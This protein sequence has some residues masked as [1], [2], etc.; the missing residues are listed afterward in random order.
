MSRQTR[1]LTSFSFAIL[2]IGDWSRS[3]DRLLCSPPSIPCDSSSR[4]R[5]Q[6]RSLREGTCARLGTALRSSSSTY[7]RP[8][9]CIG[10]GI[11]GG[12]SRPSSVPTVREGWKDLESSEE[13]GFNIRTQVL[14][15]D[16][17]RSVFPAFRPRS[18]LSPRFAQGTG[19]SGP[20]C[21]H[22]GHSGARVRPKEMGNIRIPPRTKP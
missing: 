13:S 8:P 15:L 21:Y 1:T 14:I 2:A 16:H 18:R 9:S 4:G 3:S 17:G 11:Q 6:K 20:Y 19:S 5:T 7:V 10:S 22:S 12:R